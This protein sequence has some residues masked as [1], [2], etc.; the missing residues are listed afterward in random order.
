MSGDN[1]DRAI[2]AA[3]ARRGQRP[4]REVWWQHARWY[5]IPGTPPETWDDY[6][7]SF[8]ELFARDSDELLYAMTEHVKERLAELN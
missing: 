6:A 3:I 7:D 5:T 2:M 8:I 4:L 1:G